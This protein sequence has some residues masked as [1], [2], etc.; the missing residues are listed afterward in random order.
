M[1][2][3]VDYKTVNRVC[4]SDKYIYWVKK[5]LVWVFY[6]R[7]ERDTDNGTGLKEGRVI[8][9]SNYSVPFAMLALSL[10][11]ILTFIVFRSS[12]SVTSQCKTWRQS[13]AMYQQRTDQETRSAFPCFAM[14]GN[15]VF[16][17]GI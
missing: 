10:L 9:M 13:T 1:N 8:K 11:K 2:E 7:R 17:I 4:K 3:K 15:Y 6:N 14:Y 12:F 16:W 5:R